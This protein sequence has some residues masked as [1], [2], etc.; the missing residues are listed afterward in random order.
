MFLWE[1]KSVY[2]MSVFLQFCM[3]NDENG[4]YIGAGFEVFCLDD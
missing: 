2:N 3:R 1:H 4:R